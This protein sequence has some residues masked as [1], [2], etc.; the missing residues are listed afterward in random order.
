MSKN[1]LKILDNISNINNNSSFTKLKIIIKDTIST[2]IKNALD[3]VISNLILK[4]SL[5]EIITLKNVCI[6]MIYYYNSYNLIDSNNYF[7]DIINSENIEDT[8]ILI[9]T[10]NKFIIY[11]NYPYL[12]NENYN[13]IELLYYVCYFIIESSFLQD[14][15]LIIEDFNKNE[16]NLSLDKILNCLFESKKEINILNDIYNATCKS[17]D[18]NNSMQSYSDISILYKICDIKIKETKQVIDVFLKLI[19]KI[20]Y[21]K[22]NSDSEIIK[23]FKLYLFFNLIY[24]FYYILEI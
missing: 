4:D 12:L 10:V 6:I 18:N 24:F 14:Y 11:S 22:I 5:Y 23:Y 8:K 19:N 9:N 16:T 2:I 21:S 13:E 1:N 20:N 17:F 3:S 7:Y 15:Q